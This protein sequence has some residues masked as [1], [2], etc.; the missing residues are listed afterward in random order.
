MSIETI[1]ILLLIAALALQTWRLHFV[2]KVSANALN[3]AATLLQCVHAD[4]KR[5]RDT[6]AKA[7]DMVD[8][9]LAKIDAIESKEGGDAVDESD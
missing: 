9:L 7:A 6:M 4:S 3:R 8:G 1:A 5:Q 2:Q